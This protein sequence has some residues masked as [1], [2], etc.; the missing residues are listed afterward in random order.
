ML[1]V[2]LIRARSRRRLRVCQK[3][4]PRRRKTN[5][6]ARFGEVDA[7]DLEHRLGDHAMLG[8]G[9]FRR[10]DLGEMVGRYF[11]F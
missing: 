10:Q 7:F 6:G 2:S 4:P 1:R 9:D 8:T 5:R 11:C 3:S